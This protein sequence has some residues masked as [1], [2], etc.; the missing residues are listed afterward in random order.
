MSGE[1]SLWIAVRGS[2]ATAGED[3][4]KLPAIPEARVDVRV[5]DEE[6]RELTECWGLS[7][8]HEISFRW[9][10]M[11]DVDH[12]FDQICAAVGQ[13]LRRMP[14]APAVLELN[15][16][17]LLLRRDETGIALDSEDGFWTEHRRRVLG[18]VHRLEP[19]DQA[20]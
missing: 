20:Y 6:D 17:Y 16:D 11:G 12:A 9:D 3:L 10:K 13:I 5:C 18:C 8:T 2:V 15:N 14:D 7:A 19:L 4:G 1:L